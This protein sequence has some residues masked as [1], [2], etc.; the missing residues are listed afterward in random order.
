MKNLIRFFIQFHFAI[1]FIIIE[2]ISLSLVFQYNHY[3]KA[4]GVSLV[5]NISGYYHSKVFSITEYLNLRESNQRL[6]KENVRL[7][8]ILQQAYK[9][10]DIFFYKQDDT[11]NKQRYYLTSAKVINNSVN[12]KHNFITLN[13]GSEQGLTQDMAVI[14]SDG[15]VGVIFDV[16]RYYATVISLLNTNLKISAKLK[17]NDYFGSLVWEGKD[18]RHAILNEIPYHVVIERGDTIVTSSYSAIFPEGILI[19]TI[20]DFKIKGGNFYEIIVALSTDFKH[21][22]YVSAVSNLKKEEQKELEDAFPND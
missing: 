2:F 16:S 1:F 22:T 19:G 5:Q 13:K 15:V 7:N 3:Q 6:A 17:K 18:Y 10:D 4:K 11:L 21:L 14:S 20:E 8:N 12:K 9:A